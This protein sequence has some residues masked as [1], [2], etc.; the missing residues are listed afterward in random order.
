MK[1]HSG[2]R[3]L[4][5]GQRDYS[6]SGIIKYVP[7]KSRKISEDLTSQSVDG[8]EKGIY[9][10]SRLD[11]SVLRSEVKGNGKEAMSLEKGINASRWEHSVLGLKMKDNINET[12]DGTFLHLPDKNDAG[13]YCDVASDD[14]NEGIMCF[15]EARFWECNILFLT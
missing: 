1:R 2:P 14:S 15:M 11:H 13:M 10:G 5:S 4:C 7:K 6:S 9:N 3:I 8:S 12:G